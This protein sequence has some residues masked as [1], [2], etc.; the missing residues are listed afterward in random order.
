[1]PSTCYDVTVVKFINFPWSQFLHYKIGIIIRCSNS[2][3]DNTDKYWRKKYKGQLLEG[4]R[5]L[6]AKWKFTI[7]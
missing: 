4:F 2:F 6:E 7:R 3:V 1:M 5:D